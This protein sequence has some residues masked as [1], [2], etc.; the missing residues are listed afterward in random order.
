MVLREVR[1]TQIVIASLDYFLGSFGNRNRGLSAG[2]LRLANTTQQ[3]GRAY[4]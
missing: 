1:T 2:Y 3:A 4:I